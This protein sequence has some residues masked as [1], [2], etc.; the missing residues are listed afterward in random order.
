MNQVNENQSN[1]HDDVIARAKAGLNEFDKIIG[2]YNNDVNVSTNINNFSGTIM[3]NQTNLNSTDE[4]EEEHEIPIQQWIDWYLQIPG[5]EFL[6]PVSMQFLLD[7]FSMFEF[8]GE[9]A[10][11][12]QTGDNNNSK[13]D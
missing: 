13:S 3:N 8:I 2:K 6:V 1:E 9:E 7:N 12:P 4:Y 5:N 11:Y 10:E